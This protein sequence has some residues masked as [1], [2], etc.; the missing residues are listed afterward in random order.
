MMSVPVM[1]TSA[2][3]H[4][5]SSQTGFLNM[6]MMLLYYKQYNMWFQHHQNEVNL[7]EASWISI[8]NIVYN[9]IFQ[10][11]H[12]FKNWEGFC[13]KEIWRVII[14]RLVNNSRNTEAI[15]R[16]ALRSVSLMLSSPS[17]YFSAEMRLCF[18]HSKMAFCQSSI[19][20][21]SILCRDYWNLSQ[22]ISGQGNTLDRW[23]I[24]HRSSSDRMFWYMRNILLIVQGEHSH[25]LYRSIWAYTIIKVSK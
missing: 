6:M 12:P 7:I 10:F 9:V 25:V 23:P 1:A 24:N 21:S 8:W 4:S 14:H 20:S 19:H 22:Q 5:I 15:R 3:Q 13:L 18:D 17:K 2:G 16:V 11:L